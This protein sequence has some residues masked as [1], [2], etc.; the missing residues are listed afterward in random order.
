MHTAPLSGPDVSTTTPLPVITSGDTTIASTTTATTEAEV[1]RAGVPE[2]ERTYSSIWADSEIGTGYAQSTIDSPDAWSAKVEQVGEW[3]QMDLGATEIVVGTAIQARGATQ[4]VTEYT[5]ETSIDGESWS[6]VV[7]TYTFS[8]TGDKTDTKD[9]IFTNNQQIRA[10]Y[11]RIVVQKWE[12]HIALR[13][14]V[15]IRKGMP[16]RV[17]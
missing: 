16:P 7:G 13:A 8:Y 4:Y 12:G 1:V 17:I 9:N 3:M 14:D 5:V 11:V 2:N 6:D 15:L 10:R